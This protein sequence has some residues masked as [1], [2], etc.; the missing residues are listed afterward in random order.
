MIAQSPSRWLVSTVVLGIVAVAIPFALFA[1]DHYLA[2]LEFSGPLEHYLSFN[3]EAVSNS[4]GVL[5]SIIAAVLGIIITVASII[6]QLAATRYTPAI[7]EMFFTDRTNLLVLG[8][9]VV[10]CVMGFWTAFGVNAGWVPRVSLIAMLTMATVGFVIMA[11]YFAYVFRLLAPQSVVQRIKNEAITASI[12]SEQYTSRSI[13]ERQ[14]RTLETTEQLTDIAINSISQKD[15]IIA[16]ACVDALRD[17]ASAYLERSAKL[18]EDWLEIT[19]TIRTNPD[20]ASMA[21]DSVAEIGRTRTWFEFKVLRQ[22]QAIYTEA[23]G[24]MRD[25]NYVV[26]INTRQIAEKALATDRQ[27]AL[28]LSVKFFNTYLRAT[29]NNNDVRTAYTILNQYRIM[30]EAMLRSDRG[31]LCLKVAHHIKYYGHLSYQKRLAFVTETVAYDLGALCEVAHEIASDV[32][33]DLL[34]I[35]LEV[36]PSTSEGEI[37]ETSLRGVRKAQVKL[38]AYYL[39]V[40][41]EELARR[42]WSDMTEESVERLA[43]IRDE[44][45]AIESKDFWEISDRG[46]N[47]DYLEPERKAMLT[48]FFRWFRDVSGE[49]RAVSLTTGEIPITSG[50][51]KVPEVDDKA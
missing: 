40:D 30:A 8:L 23:L 26:A 2:P 37:Q 6:V 46:G 31:D 41:A 51:D 15:K 36:D 35:F 38:A 13:R 28:M 29:L 45:M 27:E 43:S 48:T 21:E 24:D 42:V 10:G 5:S 1:V 19:D 22:Y 39:S 14:A 47:F 44:L 34:K 33:D 50:G 32:E 17:I 25:I 4:I 3:D 49:L 16:T 20:F 11:P 7:T 9:Y 12:G 18:G